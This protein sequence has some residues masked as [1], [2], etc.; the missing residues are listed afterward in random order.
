VQPVAPPGAGSPP[1]FGPGFRVAIELLDNGPIQ[2]IN[3]TFALGFGLDW[4]RFSRGGH[5]LD[6]ACDRTEVDHYYFPVVL[7]WNFW[8]TDKWSVFGEPGFAY[9]FSPQTDDGLDTFVIGG[10]A[11]FHF[12]DRFTLTLRAAHPALSVGVSVLL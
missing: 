1:G 5:C 10:G 7:Q 12:S 2:T 8:L 4:V 3:N 6:D 9:R 11:R